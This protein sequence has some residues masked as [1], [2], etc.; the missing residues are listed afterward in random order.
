MVVPYTCNRCSDCLLACLKYKDG[1]VGREESV[2]KTK[3][4]LPPYLSANASGYFKLVY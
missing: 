3:H 1:G 4:V 2:R